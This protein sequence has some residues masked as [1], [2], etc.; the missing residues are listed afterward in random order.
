MAGLPPPE[1]DFFWHLESLRRRILAA[2]AVFAAGAALAFSLMDRIMPLLCAPAAR[3]GVKLY[4]MAPFEKFVAYL[5]A[6]A[7]IGAAAALPVAAALAAGFVAPALEARSRRLLAPGVAAV[8]L[9]VLAGAALSWLVLVPFAV[10]FF[11][12]FAPADGIAPLWGL[13]AYVSLVAG[14]VAALSL[15]CLAPPVLLGLIR[16]GLLRPSTLAAGRRYAI[17]AIAIVAGVVTPTVDVV[18]QCAVGAAMW[19]LFEIT[20]LLGRIVAPGRARRP[21]EMEARDG[22]T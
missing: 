6:S 13:G 3:M 11:A 10:G 17:V 2:L 12:G 19:G 9:F 20:V 15:V 7:V 22:Q 21:P 1:R 16:A 18:S 5:K 14:L 4:A 8:C